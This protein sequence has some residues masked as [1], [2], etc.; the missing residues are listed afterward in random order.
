MADNNQPMAQGKSGGAAGGSQPG[1]ATM[2]GKSPQRE[3]GGA[4]AKP[5]VPM[6]KQNG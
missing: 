3:N 1:G 4:P 5:G 2:R 6:A